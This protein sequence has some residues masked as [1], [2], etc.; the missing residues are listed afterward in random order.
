MRQEFIRDYSCDFD[1]M[2]TEN[3]TSFLGM[4]IKQGQEGINIHLDTY[5]R[6][7]I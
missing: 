1:I 5:I 3:L 2:L 6:E 7:T 4:E